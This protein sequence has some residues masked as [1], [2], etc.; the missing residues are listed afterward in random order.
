M[1]D[2]PTD[3]AGDREKE[4]HSEKPKKSQSITFRLDSYTLNELQREADQNQISLNVLVNQALKRYSDWDRYETRIGMMPVPKAILTSLIDRVV[5]LA[6][7]SGLKDEDIGHWRD[8]IIKQAAEI[9]FNMMKDAVLFMKKQYNL[10]VVL[11][12]LQDY[13]K[14][15]GI[16]SDHRIEGGR[17]HIFVIQHELGENW[18][19]FTKELLKL[20]FENLAR[21][22]AEVNITSNMTV[23]EVIL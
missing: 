6:K 8:Q 2:V 3:S 17:K 12:V 19:L 4:T 14:V 1:I 21:V 20:I 9:A 16:N 15:S 18:S 7:E 10:W 5:D 22:K 13:M 23:A 11:T